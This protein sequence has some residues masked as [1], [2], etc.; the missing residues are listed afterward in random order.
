MTKQNSFFFHKKVTENTNKNMCEHLLFFFQKKIHSGDFK[1]VS[2]KNWPSECCA[3]ARNAITTDIPK[4]NQSNVR[5]FYILWILTTISACWNWIVI[6]SYG[7][8]DLGNDMQSYISF[9]FRC[10]QCVLHFC[11]CFIFCCFVSFERL[12]KIGTF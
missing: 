11:G 12:R 4:Q 9:F 2:L 8:T 7:F 10:L 6:F 5:K 1:Y 3:I